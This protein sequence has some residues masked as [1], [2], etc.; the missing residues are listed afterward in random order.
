M[1]QPDDA[2][3]AHILSLYDRDLHVQA[4]QAMRRHGDPLA[5]RSA[6]ACLLAAR[7]VRNI[8]GR[9][10]APLL[11]V[12][13][14]RLDRRDPEVAY[15]W[16]LHLLERRGPLAAWEA[17]ADFP[18]VDDGDAVA[19]ARFHLARAETLIVLRDFEAADGE[20]RAAE[21]LAPELAW[22]KL[23][24]ATW[25]ERQDR[26]ADALAVVN[27]ARSD[28]PHYRPAVLL[29]AML[30]ARLG[31]GGDSLEI[32]R[33]ATR[34]IESPDAWLLLAAH[35]EDLGQCAEARRSL[36]A[37]I[38]MMPAMD[39]PAFR[40]MCASFADS[41]YRAG[42]VDLAAGFARGSG[43]PFYRRFAERLE[44]GEPARR[45]ELAVPFV[46]QD[47][48][49]C[50]PAT[51]AMLSAYHGVPAEHVAI[52]EA[53]CYDGT[54]AASE[55]S[56]AEDNGFH[57]R[58][59]TVTWDSA[60][61]LLDEGIPFT[62]TTQHPPDAHL[63]A[64]SGYDARRRTFLVRDPSIP[65]MVEM[66]ADEMLEGHAWCG[67]RGMAL[68]PAA[69]AR[70]LAASDLPDSALHDRVHAVELGLRAHDREGARLKVEA[71][72]A[73]AP[74]HPVSA[75]AVHALAA[76]DANPFPQLRALERQIA[77]HP[78]VAALRQARLSL[79]RGLTLA[80]ER[81]A[82]LEEA[83][84]D[85]SADPEI[86]RL[87]AEDLVSDARQ[88]RRAERLVRRALRA[89]PLSPK[90]YFT[91]A[92]LYVAEHRWDEARQIFRFAACLDGAFVR[93]TYVNLRGRRRLVLHDLPPA[94]PHRRGAA[95][96]AD[97]LRATRPA[98]RRTGAHA[99]PL[100]P[101]PGTHR[102]GPRRPRA[103]PGATTR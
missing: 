35:E 62:L 102:R 58:E 99:Q 100:S 22:V 45:V 38:A 101:R 13:A 43:R 5:W 30:L 103:G 18:V 91:L 93:N 16:A 80:G 71:L 98:L 41:S 87:L 15:F 86:G 75:R 92:T 66:D 28:R 69:R 47:H 20:L 27:E 70:R 2:D 67:P 89:R 1:S 4:Y 3:L 83:N 73:D 49:T 95:L 24:R 50:A 37:A 90:G 81:R 56:W 12:R 85:E 31:R 36:L 42:D 39:E 65:I 97:A 10:T 6:R 7:L 55:R 96:P 44:A 54:S 59:H 26:R 76:Y 77:R 61:R 14:R 51:L 29:A 19:R 68:V 53:I 21:T 79:L 74:D 17:C 84:A 60:T 32:L 64:V 46:P 40:S 82:A 9:A 88:H 8:G 25:L 33:E 63:Q 11:F 72:V 23:D 57:V 94:P 52:A 78:G 34:H 48:R